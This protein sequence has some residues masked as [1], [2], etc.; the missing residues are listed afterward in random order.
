MTTIQERV[1][2]ARTQMP[3]QENTND[4]LSIYKGVAVQA[5]M[6]LEEAKRAP[7]HQ[8]VVNSYKPD[9]TDIVNKMLEGRLPSAPSSPIE[10]S[11][12]L[13]EPDR[14]KDSKYHQSIFKEY[15]VA[16]FNPDMLNYALTLNQLEL[17]AEGW[18]CK[19][20]ADFWNAKSQAFTIGS[21]SLRKI[22]MAGRESINVARSI[23]ELNQNYGV[24]Q[25]PNPT[26]QPQ[27]GL[28]MNP[29]QK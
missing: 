21:L 26:G 4:P 5:Q 19:D 8:P 22:G 1:A 3:T 27:N 9:N 29:T 2:F 25:N 11:D 18:G 15:G 23:H 16:N 17:I 28:S 12:K 14:R 20:L 13:I 7:I 24:L 10:L 6:G